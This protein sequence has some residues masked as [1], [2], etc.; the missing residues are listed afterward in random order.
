MKQKVNSHVGEGARRWVVKLVAGESRP[1]D[2]ASPQAAVDRT[3]GKQGERKNAVPKIQRTTA[4]GSPRTNNN[5]AHDARG[6]LSEEQADRKD[7][8][9]LA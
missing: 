2:V 5:L 6:P 4:T 1:S 3:F 7:S 9:S 8:D